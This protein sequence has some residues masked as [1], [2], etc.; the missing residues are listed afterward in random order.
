MFSIH[1]LVQLLSLR[2]K[3]AL[4]KARALMAYMITSC[5]EQ[6]NVGKTMNDIQTARAADIIIQEYYYLKPDDFK[7]CFNR[8]VI[9]KYGKTYDRIDVQVIC[10]WLNQYCEDRLNEADEI[11]Y[12]EHDKIKSNELRTIEKLHNGNI[13]A[14]MGT[15]AG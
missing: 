9:G 11:S 2:L 5:I 4:Q 6:L 7:L 14:D 3:K 12:L 10:D 13:G 15:G 8:A 1:R